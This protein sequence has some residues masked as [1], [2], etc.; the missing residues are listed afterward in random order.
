MQELICLLC[1]IIVF[2]HNNFHVRTY[3]RIIVN[4]LLQ[5]ENQVNDILGD[6]ISRS[7]LGAEDCRNRSRRNFSGFDL[8]IFINNIKRIQLLPFILMETFYLDIK[9]RIRADLNILCIFQICAQCFFVLCLISRSFSRTFSSSLYCRSFSSS[10]AS[11][12]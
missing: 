8:Q 12:L 9:N 1:N 7:R 10:E 4:N 5:T 3:F 11:F 2:Y 6:H